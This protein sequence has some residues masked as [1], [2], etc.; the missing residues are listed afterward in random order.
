MRFRSKVRN[1][2]NLAEIFMI[3][4]ANKWLFVTTFFLFFF[5]F[6]STFFFL[7]GVGLF[8]F[9]LRGSLFPSPSLFL[10][11]NKT[12]QEHKANI[13]K[14]FIK[15]PLFKHS[16][17]SPFFGDLLYDL[18]FFLCCMHSLSFAH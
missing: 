6:L 8:A 3:I 14:N 4:V 5:C 2:K 10:L 9:Y 7:S 18:F 11:R 1:P 12:K 16:I 15:N 17:S 13:T